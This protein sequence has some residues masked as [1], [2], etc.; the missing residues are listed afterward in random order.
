MS[1]SHNPRTGLSAI[2]GESESIFWMA[3]VE[4]AALPL[5]MHCYWEGADIN[6][7]ERG[8]GDLLSK[9]NDQDINKN[10]NGK[11]DRHFPPKK[12][13]P[14]HQFQN[15]I[16]PEFKSQ[17][18]SARLSSRVFILTEKANDH[19]ELFRHL[20]QEQGL[21]FF[22]SFILVADFRSAEPVEPKAFEVT[23]AVTSSYPGYPGHRFP[24]RAF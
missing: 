18:N 1:D 17:L 7:R 21:F 3:R 22:S 4:A 16:S 19:P 20:F 9:A 11:D 12:T 13:P 24:P 8:E 6:R 23:G 2:R 14:I 15:R 10:K 5:S